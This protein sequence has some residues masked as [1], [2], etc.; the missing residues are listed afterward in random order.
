[1]MNNPSL[2]TEVQGAGTSVWHQMGGATG[3]VK[4]LSPDGRNESVIGPGG[5]QV[6]GTNAATY[7]YG[8]AS[9]L[10][11]IALDVIP[12]LLAGTHSPGDDA[13]VVDRLL[14]P[15]T[16]PADRL[17]AEFKCASSGDDLGGRAT[18]R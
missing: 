12:F 3:N 11:H 9:G 16:V 6:T 4:L 1:M 17:P 8:G 14:A 5:Q 2:A 15:L 18:C 7:N 10:D 13:S